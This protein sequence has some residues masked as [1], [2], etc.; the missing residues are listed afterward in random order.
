[1]AVE[2]RELHIKAVVGSDSQENRSSRSQRGADNEEE[3][4]ALI[5]LCVERVL[6]ILEK[7]TER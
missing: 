6:E 4:E 3:R 5:A 7:E 2:I 1:M